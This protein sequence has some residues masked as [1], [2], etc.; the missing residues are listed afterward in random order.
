MRISQKTWLNYITKLDQIDSKAAELMTRWVIDNGLDDR[1]ALIEYSYAV[2]TKYGEA[3][4]AL[5]CEM[6]DAIAMASGASVPPAVPAETATMQ[7]VAKAVNGSLKR[8]EVQVPQTVSQLTRRT[9]ADTTLQ[10]AIRDGAQ[11]AW[12]PHGDTC[13]F[14]MVLASNGWQNVSKQTLKKGHAEHIHANCDCQYGVR[15][16][17]RDSVAGYDPKKYKEMYDNAEGSTPQEKI[18]Y[19]RRE[20]YQT[21]KDR[22]NAMK[23]E[24]YARRQTG[25]RIT[26]GHH[27]KTDESEGKRGLK[28]AEQYEQFARV[29]DSEIIANN[30]GF[31]VEDI[32]IIRSHVFYEK[33]DLD[34]GYKRFEP[35]Y[36]MAVAWR[37]LQ[38]GNYLPRDITLLNHE[39]LESQLEKRYNLSAREA[40][41]RTQETYNW[42]KQLME[43]TD[44]KGEKD[45]LL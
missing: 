19:M 11:Y 30:T 17:E 15:F 18:N 1:N 42:V 40:H 8:S 24:A 9:A 41:E 23:R 39:L 14:C 32:R 33:H 12:I 26:G 35:D 44:G 3:A 45:D 10:N 7:E 4:A 38:N 37:R 20:Q 6:Y 22:I 43:E 27:Y 34:E 25:G 31:S 13:V 28:A 36:D 29:D 16:S 5:A 21:D 2:C